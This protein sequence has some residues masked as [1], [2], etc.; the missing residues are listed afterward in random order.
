[1][2]AFD[3]TYG[4]PAAAP[5][6]RILVTA[7]T[8]SVPEPLLAQ[9]AV[10]GRLVVPIGPPGKQRPPRH[11]PPQDR[12]R[13]GGRRGRHVR[14]S[15][16]ALRR[17]PG[18]TARRAVVSGRVQG[19]GFRFFAERAAGSAG[20]RGWVR[21]L[22]DGS[23]ET[24]AEGEEDAVSRYLAAQDGPVRFPCG[25]GR[26]GRA[27]AAGPHGVRDHG[28]TDFRRY[29]TDVPDFPSAGDPVSRRHAAARSVPKPSGRGRGDGRA[30]RGE[31]PGEVSG[32]RRAAS[33]SGRPSPGSSTSVSC[34]S[35]SPGKLP[36]QDREG[37]LRPRVRLGQPRGARRRVLARRAALVV[38]DVLATG[39]TA[40]GRGGARREARRPVGGFPSSSS[41]A[42]LGGRRAS[43]AARARRLGTINS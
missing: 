3:G 5:Y 41:S 6:D 17:K 14:A 1:M 23:V 9:L 20:V 25:R 28:M 13:P 43:P 15:A 37:R 10:G 26:R 42:A 36:A 32:S 21:N 33:C 31:P 16:R 11:P 30:F 2:K 27:P 12:L 19:V 35:A 22:P 34:R 24:V 7:G 38:D 8:E 18:V 39:G 29:I 40:A 4:Y